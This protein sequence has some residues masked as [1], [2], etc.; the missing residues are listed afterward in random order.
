MESRRA[1]AAQV[2]NDRAVAGGMKGRKDAVPGARIV[3]PAVK[4]ERRRALCGA[5]ELTGDGERAR[6]EMLQ[7]GCT[8]LDC[9]FLRPMIPAASRSL[10]PR[11]EPQMADRKQLPGKFVWFR[12][13]ERRV[14]KECRSRW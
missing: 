13:E 3:G 11:K 7:L 12:S 5:R 9:P 1:E 10:C 4:Q 6:S 2:G 8:H 14:G